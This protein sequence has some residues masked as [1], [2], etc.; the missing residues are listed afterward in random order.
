[1][2][3]VWGGQDVL[4]KN[5]LILLRMIW[6]CLWNAFW[7]SPERIS[8]LNL[9]LRSKLRARRMKHCHRGILRVNLLTHERYQGVIRREW[10]LT[11]CIQ[12]QSW[13]ET[14]GDQVLGDP[15]ECVV[16]SSGKP[17]G[18]TQGNG[19]CS[20]EECCK[21]VYFFWRAVWP[22]LFDWKVYI[23]WA[24]DFSIESYTK[25]TAQSLLQ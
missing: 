18:H 6:E 13:Q 11:A 17:P 23:H 15:G 24:R 12:E 22:N 9:W 21:L 1:M 7:L 5:I 4:G 20:W 16:Q 2:R 10:T 14:E 8:K 3:L 25:V 19:A